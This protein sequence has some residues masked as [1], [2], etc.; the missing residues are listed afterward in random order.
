MNNVSFL[1]LGATLAVVSIAAITYSA[2]DLRNTSLK[3]HQFFKGIRLFMYLYLIPV[4]TII[5]ALNL[6]EIIL[7]DFITVTNSAKPFIYIVSAIT[8]L[9]F[10]VFFI[11]RPVNNGIALFRRHNRDN[12]K[13]SR[14]ITK[15]RNGHIIVLV[16]TALTLFIIT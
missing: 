16:L 9:V 8:N 13:Y 7:Q 11:G 5:L 15:S 2:S 4:F 14:C 3:R 12:T 10:I 6:R 1:L